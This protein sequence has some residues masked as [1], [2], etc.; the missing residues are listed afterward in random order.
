M[1]RRDLL[2]LLGSSAILPFLPKSSEALTRFGQ[3]IHQA[4]ANGQLETLK[5]AQGQL[6]SAVADVVL[7]R[8]DTPG[9]TDIGVTA[10]VDR[11][12]GQWYNQEERSQFLAGLADLDRRA[13]GD[14][15]TLTPDRKLALLQS[16]DGAEGPPTSAEAAFN[17]LKS[18]TIYGYFTSE[19]VMK[20]VT[21]DPLIPGRFQG[22]VRA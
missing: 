7:P 1:Q 19:K 11:I 2:R 5:P 22:C 15:L 8:T 12:V 13:G 16:L 3:A 9:A 18:L 21:R 20:E 17:R 10:F 6:V 14:F 4:A